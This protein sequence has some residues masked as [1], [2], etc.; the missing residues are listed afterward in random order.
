MAITIDPDGERI[1]LD[2]V[3]YEVKIKVDKDDKIYVTVP[4]EME[5][6]TGL[7]GNNDGNPNSEY[8]TKLS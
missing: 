4:K 5:G 7:C 3:G 1:Y 2:I 6:M 8:T